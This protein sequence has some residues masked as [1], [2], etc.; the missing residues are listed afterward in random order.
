VHVGTRT[1]LGPAQC[2]LVATTPEH[3]T[4]H[5]TTNNKKM[6][7]FIFSLFTKVPQNPKNKVLV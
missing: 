1:S 3:Q 2:S 7:V 6:K 5:T 4:K